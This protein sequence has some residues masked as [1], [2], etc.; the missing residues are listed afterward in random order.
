MSSA[1]KRKGTA[2][3]TAVVNWLR[4]KGYQAQRNRAGWTDDRGDV[5]AINGVVIEVKN[6]Q[7]HNWSSYF[8]QLGRQMQDKQAYTGVILCKRPGH[9]NPGKWLAVMPADLW[10]ELIQLLEETADGIQP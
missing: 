2:A 7:Q 4:E 1:N 8:E 10:L 5:D 3:E 6:R 9:A